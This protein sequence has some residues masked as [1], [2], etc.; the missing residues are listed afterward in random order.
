[1]RLALQGD[2]CWAGRD[3]LIKT[4]VRIQGFEMIHISSLL[5]LLRQKPEIN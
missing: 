3:K 4:I 5:P 2:D 1:M